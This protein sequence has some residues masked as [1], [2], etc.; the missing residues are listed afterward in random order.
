MDSHTFNRRWDNADGEK[1]GLWLASGA[2]A[3]III[4][5]TLLALFNH[6]LGDPLRTWSLICRS[7]EAKK[8]RI[9]YLENHI[10]SLEATSPAQSH[11]IAELTDERNSQDARI[12]ELVREIEE[13]KRHRDEVAQIEELKDQLIVLQH[14][15]TDSGLEVE[16]CERQIA[17]RLK[18]D[19]AK[20][21]AIRT[22]WY[23]AVFPACGKLKLAHEQTVAVR[24]GLIDLVGS[25]VDGSTL[26]IVKSAEEQA[27]ARRLMDI[28]M[29]MED[30]LMD[31]HERVSVMH[32]LMYERE[33]ERE[34]SIG[35]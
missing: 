3:S 7:L 22:E 26:A 15:V 35:S 21:K 13:L 32:T 12:S 18:D 33:I 9:A 2:L 8:Q 24:D 30:A 19:I 16:N 14:K 6:A 10:K 25:I 31:T 34:S 11:Q 4:F 17:E 28:L 1:V 27:E 20:L 29:E 23:T 5:G